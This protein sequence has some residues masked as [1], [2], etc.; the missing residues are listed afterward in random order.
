MHYDG[1]HLNTPGSKIL[2]DNFILALNTLTWHRISQ[3][4]NALDKDNSETESNSKFSNNLS[5][6]TLESKS[7]S[8]RNVE[9]LCFLKESKI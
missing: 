3:E 2:A 1:I 5:E 6:D 4:N 8:H 7:K 9:N